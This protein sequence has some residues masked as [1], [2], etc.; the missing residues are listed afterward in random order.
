MSGYFL[1]TVNLML[2]AVLSAEHCAGHCDH[3]VHAG[4]DLLSGGDK[5]VPSHELVRHVRLQ[6]VHVHN[7]LL[8]CLR[9][10]VSPVT[11]VIFVP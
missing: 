7:N 11:A 3:A 4:E 1:I 5:M 9:P 6:H 10:P 8:H 2:Q